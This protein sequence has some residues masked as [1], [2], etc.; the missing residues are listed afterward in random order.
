MDIAFRIYLTLPV[1]NASEE[2]SFTN[3][4]LKK[5]LRSPMGQEILSHLTLMSLE[6][7]FVRALDFTTLALPGVKPRGRHLKSRNGL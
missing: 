5:S 3:L 7:D 2:H 6:S 4:G 1:T